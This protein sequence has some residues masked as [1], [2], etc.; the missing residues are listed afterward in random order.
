MRNLI[1]LAEHGDIDAQ[2][3]LGV[4]YA[5]GKGVNQDYGKAVFWFQKAAQQGHMTAQY[6]IAQ[7]YEKELGVCQNYALAFYWYQKAAEQG[8]VDA[9]TNIALYYY[10]GQGTHKDYEEAVEWWEKSANLGDARACFNL[11]ICF[12]DGTGVWKNLYEAESW[13]IK[14]NELGHPQAA[15]ALEQMKRLHY[16]KN[17][18][19]GDKLDLI[20]KST[21]HQRY[22]NGM[23]VKGSQYCNRQIKIEHKIFKDMFDGLEVMPREGFLITMLNTDVEPPVQ[24]MQPKMM[25]MVYNHG[26]EILLKGVMIKAMG[27]VAHNDTDYGITLYLKNRNVVKC[28]LHMYDRGVDIEYDEFTK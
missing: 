2:F 8:D 6:N 16:A 10:L 14:A 27:Y 25:E 23:P 24:H 28:V 19:K 5:H 9:M 7:C 22:Q 12:R 21:H 18:V 17:E 3:E 13:F 15:H 11:G 1:R 4:I 20:L 26:D